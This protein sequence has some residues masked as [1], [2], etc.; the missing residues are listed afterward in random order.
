VEAETVKLLDKLTP[1]VKLDAIEFLAASL[2]RAAMRDPASQIQNMRRLFEMLG[3][4]PVNN[5][6][7]GFCSSD[8]D[9]EIYR[10]QP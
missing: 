2:R 8:H 1:A 4:L 9:R 3:T 5:P 6:S 7:D 10:G